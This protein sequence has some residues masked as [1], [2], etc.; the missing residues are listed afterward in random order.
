MQKKTHYRAIMLILASNNNEIYKNCRKVW[1][2]YMNI[3]E[4]IK[5]Y[6]VYGKIDNIHELYLYDNK[7]DLIFQ[8]IPES[9]PVYINKTIE[10]MKVIDSLHTYDYFIRTNLTTFWDFK[11]LHLHLNDLPNNNCYSGDGP[12]PGYNSNGYYVSGT[13]TIVTSEMIKSII[14]NQHLV[15][16]NH[17]EDGAMGKFFHMILGAPILPNRICFFDDIISKNE[18]DKIKSRVEEAV[19]NGKD[20]YRVK[21]LNGNREDIDMFIYTILLKKIYNIE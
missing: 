17:V 14:I 10:A 21:T 19:K 1:K 12:L 13:D 7:T 2:K 3:D 11:K 6:F 16:Y 15:D 20:H 9:Y 4:T 8:H 18:V 5:V